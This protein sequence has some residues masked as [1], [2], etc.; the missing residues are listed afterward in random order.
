M[1]PLRQST[2]V[3]VLIGPFLDS[4]DGNTV[5]DGLTISQA[6][7]RL[8]KNGGNMAQKNEA[9]NA[10]HDELGFYSCP[11]DATDTNTLGRLKLVVHESGALSVWHDFVIMA[12]SP[13]D[14][15]VSEYDYLD[16]NT[17]E[18]GSSAAAVAD[19]V[20]DEAAADH[21]A[22]GSFGAQAGTDID[23]I[24]A[25]TNE[26]QTDDIPTLI[27]ALNDLSAA[28]VNS[29]VVDVL[30]TDTIA[31]MAQGIP[32]TTPTFEEAVMYLYM[33]LTKQTD[34]TSDLQEYHDDAGTVLWKQTLTKSTDLFRKAK[35]A[36]GP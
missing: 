19:A 14:S 16:V 5:E 21:V 6:D 7:V 2:A 24:L 34:V 36:S 23:A 28:N 10:T 9:S 26:L 8:S 11:L 4:T 22:G 32:P 18:G 20:W 29:E 1:Q 3:T 12:A 25:D 35:G 17:V 27:G 13:Y 31:E 33:A 30:K 15:L